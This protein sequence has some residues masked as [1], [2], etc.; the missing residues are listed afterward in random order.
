MSTLTEPESHFYI[1]QLRQHRLIQPVYGV[2]DLFL[3]FC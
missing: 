1:G 3:G 2:I